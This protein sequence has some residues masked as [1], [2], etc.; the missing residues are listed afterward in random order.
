MIPKPQNT[1]PAKVQQASPDR[2]LS[3]VSVLAAIYLDNQ[4]MRRT[5]AIYDVGADRVLASKFEPVDLSASK[6]FP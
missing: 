4:A 1:V 5:I 2:V 6:Q 3:G